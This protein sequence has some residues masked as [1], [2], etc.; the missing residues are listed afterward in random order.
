MLGPGHSLC[1][2]LLG[3]GAGMLPF[4]PAPEVHGGF[5]EVADEGLEACLVPRLGQGW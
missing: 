4:G 2:G 1:S 3:S 5:C